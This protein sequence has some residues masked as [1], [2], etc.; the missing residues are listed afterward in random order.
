[1]HSAQVEQSLNSLFNAHAIQWRSHVLWE[2]FELKTL[3]GATH[4]HLADGVNAGRDG[5]EPLRQLRELDRLAVLLHGR[6]GMQFL[7]LG[8]DIQLQTNAAD[9]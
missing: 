8:N 3:P 6:L 7:I 4:R 5:A 2:R 9:K 1:M